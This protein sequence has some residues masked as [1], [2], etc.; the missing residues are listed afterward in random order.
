MT[1]NWKIV[2]V[3]SSLSVAFATLLCASFL[4]NIDWDLRQRRNQQSAYRDMQSLGTALEAYAKTNGEF[5]AEF[6]AVREKFVIEA[7]RSLPIYG[8]RSYGEYC[9]QR[10]SEQKPYRFSYRRLDSSRY[11]LTAAPA[12]FGVTGFRGYFKNADG[13]VRWHDMGAAT[14][15]DPAPSRPPILDL[16]SYWTKRARE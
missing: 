12:E 2:V 14:A 13:P 3:V 4:D 16:H 8:D 11:E 6:S 10:I 9:W 15:S 7:A 5:P 1:R